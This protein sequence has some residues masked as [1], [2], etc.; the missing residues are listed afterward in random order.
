MM[1]KIRMILAASAMML[2]AASCTSNQNNNESAQKA[3]DVA[4]EWKVEK[5]N[6]AEVPETMNETVLILNAEDKTYC[7]ATGVNTLNGDYSLE[8]DIIK[9]AEGAMT[10]MMGDS[11]SMVVEGSLVHALYAAHTA[12]LEDGTLIIKD[13]EGKTLLTLFKK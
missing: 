10:Q 12:T 13:A 1:K 8:G 3:M 2:A 7:A 5:L 6:D 4:G 9:F 11:V